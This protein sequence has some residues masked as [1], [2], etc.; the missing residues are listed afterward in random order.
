MY[1]KIVFC[2]FAVCSGVFADASSHFQ[3]TRYVYALDKNLTLEGYISFRE[4]SILL[5][6]VKPENKL[7]TYYEGNLSI[8]D[9]QGYRTI[10]TAQMPSLRYLFTVIKAVHDEDQSLLEHFFDASKHG[11]T[12][13]LT[14]K[15]AVQELLESIDVV[16]KKAV[17][18]SLHVR[19]KNGDRILIEIQD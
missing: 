13:H 4:Q 16:T 14:P 17:L 15:G 3:E 10:D 9:A 1:A 7:L 12:L 11:D 5:E 2:L 18:K 8:Q 19:M 6:Y